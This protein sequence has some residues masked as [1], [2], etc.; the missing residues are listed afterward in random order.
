MR[1]EGKLS[2]TDVLRLSSWEMAK[3][4]PFFVIGY[5]I[6]NIFLP[7]FTFAKVSEFD[8]DLL[9]PYTFNDKELKKL[10]EKDSALL[11]K[12]DINENGKIDGVGINVFDTDDSG[13]FSEE[14]REALRTDDAMLNKL[15][16]NS[17]NKI[18]DEEFDRAEEYLKE[19][20]NANG[21]LS[22][23]WKI[24]GGVL[25]SF[26]L[27]LFGIS[28]K[29]SYSYKTLE[30]RDV[31]LEKF[32]KFIGLRE[33]SLYVIA[34][35]FAAA[36]I[37]IVRGP[38]VLFALVLSTTL[39]FIF[40]FL[41]GLKAETKG[42]VPKPRGK[43]ADS[44]D[45]T[46][47]DDGVKTLTCYFPSIP[48]EKF[49][50]IE[51]KAAYGVSALRFEDCRRRNRRNFQRNAD[52]APPTEDWPR[53]YI[54]SDDS[55]ETMELA[56]KFYG[57]ADKHG[58]SEYQLV[59]LILAA[60]KSTTYEKDDVSAPEMTSL[61]TDDVEALECSA[62]DKLT[63]LAYLYLKVS[64]SGTNTEE[65]VGFTDKEKEKVD[66]FLKNWFDEWNK[67]NSLEIHSTDL[68]GF[69]GEVTEY[70]KAENSGAGGG[71]A[72]VRFIKP[73]IEAF[74]PDQHDRILREM[75]EVRD[76]EELR[77]NDRRREYQ[78]GYVNYITKRFADHAESKGEYK[79]TR[80]DEY[81]RY[82]T[83]TLYEQ[84][85]DCEDNAMLFAAL[86]RE[87][88]LE[89]QLLEMESDEIDPTTKEKI[90]HMACAVKI[91]GSDSFDEYQTHKISGYVYCETTY[92]GWRA[93]QM[94]PG[95]KVINRFDV[96][97]LPQNA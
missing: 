36:I 28:A 87:F 24:N 83:E 57:L 67:G 31:F 52:N 68:K 26:F 3:L 86:I 47:Q 41:R 74:A 79:T 33:I 89:V 42:P 93:G 4:A 66:I 78:V 29:Y 91:E 88:H 32:P 49:Q 63:A 54:S 43:V 7:H 50:G 82:P 85:G 5:F 21:Y 51:M 15:D 11:A 75:K 77:E 8:V 16:E 80:P 1:I 96:E 10:A 30:N 27:I 18:D 37:T 64:F 22:W 23:G 13:S 9:D 20:N 2:W 60:V 72:E 40:A 56:E 92:K 94:P 48:G 81:P 38:V 71:D 95:L 84:I 44:D 46:A 19:I 69:I 76:I 34:F 25:L 6:F 62:K 55:R 35:G 45:D 65:L 53:I 73:A 17:N 58:L 14:E 97:A 90:K 12:L 39:L 61:R 70:V 59:E